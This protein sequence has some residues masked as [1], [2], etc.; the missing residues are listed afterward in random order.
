MRHRRQGLRAKSLNSLTMRSI[1]ATGSAPPVSAPGI[2]KAAGVARCAAPFGDQGGAGSKPTAAR[3]CSS[4]PPPRASGRDFARRAPEQ[5]R[6]ATSGS[7]S[8]ST[9]AP[10]RAGLR[11]QPREARGVLDEAD[12]KVGLERLRC[13]HVND[14]GLPRL[15]RDRPPISATARWAATGSPPS[16]PNR[17]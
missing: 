17:A 2:W 7:D 14:A 11:V 9:H 13:V 15:P 5:L 1:S 10:L 16:S 12:A 6:P 8:A 4:R 3:C